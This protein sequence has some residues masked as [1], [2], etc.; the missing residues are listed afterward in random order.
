MCVPK[1]YIYVYY[2]LFLYVLYVIMST[3]QIIR[4]RGESQVPLQAARCAEGSARQVELVGGPSGQ[5]QLQPAAISGSLAG[6][7]SA[8]GEQTP[9][10][11]MQASGS[12]WG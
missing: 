11:V 4:G 3:V 5:L 1:N 6:G 7:V 10:G 2:I 8:A 9:V 12:G